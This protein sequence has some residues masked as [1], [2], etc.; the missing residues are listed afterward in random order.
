[1]G[2]GCADD[3]TC[4]DYA[5]CSYDAGVDGSTEASLPAPS[6]DAADGPTHGAD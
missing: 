6:A 3:Y 2:A 1:M 5:T 4:A